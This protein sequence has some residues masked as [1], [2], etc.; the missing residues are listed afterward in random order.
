[1][2]Q[3]VQIDS[4]TPGQP[5]AEHSA[6]SGRDYHCGINDDLFF[7][8]VDQLKRLRRFL[9]Q[10]AIPIGN[11]DS[12]A[13]QMGNL[14]VLYSTPTGRV[15]TVDEWNQVERQMQLSYSALTPM[16]RRRFLLSK[17]PR[18]LVILPLVF[19]T[20]AVLSEG[21]VIG[22][23]NFSWQPLCFMLFYLIWSGSLGSL[24]AIASIG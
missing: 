10:E 19:L 14:H 21:F 8:Y 23:L 1:M 9:S 17:T 4:P 3:A 22:V 5:S 18:N 2:G 24:G 15:P 13:L 11:S 20:L 7:E 12:E 6:H 16:L